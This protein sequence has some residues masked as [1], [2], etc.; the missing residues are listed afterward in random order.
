VSVHSTGR[1][2]YI[3]L[4]L[5]QHVQNN[6]GVEE[7]SHEHSSMFLLKISIIVFLVDIRRLEAA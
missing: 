3:G 4:A 7:N 1:R 2:F 5:Q 6:V